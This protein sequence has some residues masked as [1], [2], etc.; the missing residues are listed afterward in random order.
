MTLLELKT[1]CANYHKVGLSDL[2]VLGQDLGLAAL[3]QV[4]LTAELDH[5]FNFNR[6]L[7]SLSVSTVTGASLDSAVIY[8]TATTVN[9]KTILDVGTF[10]TGGNFVPQDWT[11]IEEGL[12]RQR[13]D[14]PYGGLRYQ[15]DADIPSSPRGSR[16]FTIA[17]NTLYNFPIAEVAETITVGIWADVFTA[18]WTANTT[19]AITGTTGVTAF[20]DTYYLTGEYAGRGIWVNSNP[21]TVTA[22]SGNIARILWWDTSMWLMT[23][24][25]DWGS[26][27]TGN[28]GSTAATST[29]TPAGLTFTGHGTV[30]GTPV[31][32]TATS[33]LTSANDVWTKWGAQYLQWAA[34]DQL[35]R[36]FKTYVARQEGNL[37]SPSDLAAK[38]LEAFKDWD[39]AKYEQHRRHGR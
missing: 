12:E 8:G 11:T 13:E 22:P 26:A 28:Y 37:A 21:L 19:I 3:N 39:I 33:T 4:R 18:D 15:S 34:I 6:K 25:Q 20:N 10:D 17:N 24:A 31:A 9:I 23:S 35:N 29:T 30:T 36:Y 5:D 38:G 1:A 2:T 7:L 14:N 27:A 16:R 32:G